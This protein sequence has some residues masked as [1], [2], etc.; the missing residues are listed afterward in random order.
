MPEG[1][2]DV[3]PTLVSCVLSGEAAQASQSGEGVE[4]VALPGGRSGLAPPHIFHLRYVEVET[5][6]LPHI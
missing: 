6:V 2:G 5:K 4:A 3:D 1:V